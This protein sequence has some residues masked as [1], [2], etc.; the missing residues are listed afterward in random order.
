MP[1]I[2]TPHTRESVRDLF[3]GGWPNQLEIAGGQYLTDVV[4]IMRVANGLQLGT[5]EFRCDTVQHQILRANRERNGNVFLL[6]GRGYQRAFVG[7]AWPG[8]DSGDRD[9]NLLVMLWP[10]QHD[11]GIDVI[12]IGCH[13]NFVHTKPYSTVNVTTCTK[14][15]LRRT[16]DHG[17]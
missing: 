3:R 5:V 1:L 17:D 11:T 6:T 7:A 9:P 16:I 12:E 4:S 13:H 15:D 14:C 10:H 8:M 2:T